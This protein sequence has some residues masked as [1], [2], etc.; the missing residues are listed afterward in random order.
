MEYGWGV[1]G[2]ERAQCLE[3][4]DLKALAESLFDSGRRIRV[5]RDKDESCFEA[6]LPGWKFNEHG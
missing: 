5:I 6:Q 3:N 4:G 1:S 2:R